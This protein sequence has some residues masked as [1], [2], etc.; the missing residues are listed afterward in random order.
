MTD[1]APEYVAARTVLLD[2][3][4]ALGSQRE[5]II[6]VGAQAIYMHT[7]EGGIMGYAPYTTD[8]DLAL[9][10][11]RLA[12]EPRVEKLLEDANFEQKGDPGIWWKTITIDGMPTDVEVDIMVPE[13]FAQQVGDAA[14]GSHLTTR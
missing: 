13:H 2:V 9:S 1:A 10:P 7:Q 12:H 11:A 4:E 8:A 14:S 3:L 5:A 6:V